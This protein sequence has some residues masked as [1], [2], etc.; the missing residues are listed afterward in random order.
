MSKELEGRIAVITGG[1]S[2]IGLASAKILAR[3]GATIVMGYHSNKSGAE[4]AL[5][6]LDGAG[7]LCLPIKIDVADSVE[8]ARNDVKSRFGKIDILVNSAGNTVMVPAPDLDALTDE[9]FDNLMQV[10]LRGPFTVIRAFAPLLKTGTDAVIVNI[11][12][13]ASTTGIGSNI[14]YVAAKGGLL[15][16]STALAR[17]LA[18]E[19]RVLTV[20]PAGV[21]TDFVKGRDPKTVDRMKDVMPLRKVTEP[22][23]V[24]K[25]VYSAVAHLT[26]STGIEILVD[27]GRNLRGSHWG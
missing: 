24:A 9:M 16:L 8:A 3:H 14:G 19:I 6:T 5:A 23:H 2:G 4:T 10:N 22:E 15:S 20:S 1:S 25:A 18:P 11:G 13:L 21:R 26:S 7:H 12:S 17:V 27:E